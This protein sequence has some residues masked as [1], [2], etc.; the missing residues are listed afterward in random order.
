M[1]D[2]GTH[3][4]T[5]PVSRPLQR[6]LRVAVATHIAGLRGRRRTAPRLW[7]GL[8]RGPLL[9]RTAD[10][11]QTDHTLRTEIVA[12]MAG[13][14]APATQ[15]WTPLVWLT[16]PGEVDPVE[17]LELAWLAAAGAAYAELDLRLVF[18]TVG[19][20]G[21]RDPRTGTARQWDRIRRR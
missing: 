9:S 21:W 11:D 4:L 5:E 20:H 7:V 3:G 19:R 1:I 13:R 8:P 16:R 14:I 18:V 17:D 2:P 6:L 15:P 10:T 12:Q